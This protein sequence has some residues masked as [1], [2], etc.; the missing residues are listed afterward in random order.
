MKKSNVT[1]IVKNVKTAAVKHSPEILTGIGIAGMVTTTVLAV[2]ATPKALDLI[3]RADDEKFDNGHGEHLT[4]LEVVKV[5]WKPYIPA[6]VTCVASIT[7]LIGA[8]SV[9]AK[10]NAVL[11][12]A[13]KLSES[14]LTEYREKVV[15]TIG[16]KKEQVV[17]EKIG[18]ERVKQNP[19]SNGTVYVTG[20]GEDLFLEPI[21]GKYFKSDIERLRGIVNTLNERMYGDPFDGQVSLSDFYDEIPLKRTD[22]SD[23]L[24]WRLD[25]GAIKVDYTPAICDDENSPYYNKPCLALYYITPPKYGYDK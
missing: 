10:R 8:S 20:T 3:A 13:Y 16:E 22:I 21:S 19:V 12:T 9:N 4:K 2:K 11:A 6:A 14:A 24:G 5:A 18:Q 15:E 7:C 23:D 17:R 1:S 25:W